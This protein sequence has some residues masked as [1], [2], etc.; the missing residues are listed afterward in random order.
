[1]ILG[2]AVPD[3]VSVRLYVRFIP[4]LG[5]GT[6]GVSASGPLNTVG[7][8]G[9]VVFLYNEIT[10]TAF[11]KLV[12]DPPVKTGPMDLGA[13]L[14]NASDKAVGSV[15]DDGG[16]P[17]ATVFDVTMPPLVPMLCENTTT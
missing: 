9:G 1:V 3:T 15:D 11:K 6:D 10:H 7:F 12:L 4:S 5:T 8:V 17:S 16:G 2:E 14:D 13:W